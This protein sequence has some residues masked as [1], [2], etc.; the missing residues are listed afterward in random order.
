L[1]PG[2]FLRGG[3]GRVLSR[4]LIAAVSLVTFLMAPALSV[5]AAVQQFSVPDMDWKTGWPVAVLLAVLVFIV[6]LWS[7]FRGRAR[8]RMRLLSQLFQALFEND[9]DARLITTPKGK[10]LAASAAWRARL[11][12]SPKN[13]IAGLRN[14][15]FAG[16]NVESELE[17]LIGSATD[18]E[19]CH[20]DL[21]LI[22]TPNL[23]Q[24]I[25]ADPLFGH[26]GWV[27]WSLPS[28]R[29]HAALDDAVLLGHQRLASFLDADAVGFYSLDQDGVFLSIDG[30]IAGWLGHSADDIVTARRGLGDFLA[31]IENDNG[32]ETDVGS[33]CEE[34]E[35]ALR[36]KDSDGNIF[37]V[38]YA[39]ELVAGHDG[40]HFVTRSMMR[41]LAD[42]DQ[43]AEAGAAVPL[44]SLRKSGRNPRIEN[45]DGGEGWE[46]R[47]RHLFLESPVGIAMIDREGRVRECNGALSNLLG[48]EP[49]MAA[50]KLLEELVAPAGDAMKMDAWLDLARQ[51]GTSV[52]PLSVTHLDGKA[53]TVLVADILPGEDGDGG[54]YLVVHALEKGGE[55]DIG[56]S[57]QQSQKME[58]VGQLA[59]GIA[60]DFNNLLTAMIGFCDLLLLRHSPK[61]QS[62][63]D[64]MQ[65]KQNANRAAN[66]VRQLLAFSRQQT[67]QPKVLNLTDVL[68]ELSHL[69]RRLIGARIELNMV[70]GREVGLVK[71]DQ[72]QLEQVVINLAVNARDAMTGEGALTIETGL[73]PAG[74]PRL[75][76]Y[77]DLPDGDYV[78][79][80]VID[81]GSGIPPEILEK[82]YEPFFTTKGVG[83]GTGLGL[84]T[85][86]GIVKQTGG[87]IFVDSTQGKGTCFTILLPS[88]DP[89]S[90]DEADDQPEEA[91]ASAPRLD[92]TGAGTIL[93]VEDEDAVRLFGAR[94]LRNKGYEVIE[95]KN[96]EEAFEILKTDADS[97]D[98]L[99][100]DVVMPGI[101]GPTLI[102]QVRIDHPSMKVIFISGYTEDTFRKNLDEGEVVHFLPKPFSLQQL[103]GKVKE[104][105]QE[106]AA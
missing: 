46:D 41:R 88:H 67:L 52:D 83:E 33:L 23:R 66:L 29:N 49:G 36:L 84:A 64:I 72:G 70:H 99:I 35:G 76:S 54:P 10:A 22:G 91:A 90:V 34:V 25:A 53:T 98:L 18:G 95:A 31:E 63:A 87:H 21:S 102:R 47:F 97:I 74:D 1:T 24:R 15:L 61:D 69:L 12:V 44:L 7:L 82:I 51:G 96:G 42:A 17:R 77:A 56:E 58:L 14:T 62:F 103:A 71:A 6:A 48:L 4:V 94:A 101:D 45:T 86:Y 104:V 79:V 73:I 50:G 16:D 3:H 9:H 43:D 39:Q 78:T 2:R 68:A 57:G 80:Q 92:L 11:E 8:R 20:A 65:I 55:G 105:M 27:V 59:G 38:T 5:S 30:T 26:P 100:T 89:K 28:D 37:H 75:R 60:H 81:T 106:D 13:P 40:R 19:A 32:S 93:L 85:V